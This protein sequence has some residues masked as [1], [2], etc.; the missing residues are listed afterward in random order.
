MK[1]RHAILAIR[2]VVLNPLAEYELDL[3]SQVGERPNMYGSSAYRGIACVGKFSEN[4]EF[5][6][7]SAIFWASDLKLIVELTLEPNIT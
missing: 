2:L 6:L 1:P 4:L 7:L 3:A 5:L